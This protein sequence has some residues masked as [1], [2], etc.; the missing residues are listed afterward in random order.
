[1]PL[2]VVVLPPA[3]EP[4]ASAEKSAP[5]YRDED[6]HE[7]IPMGDRHSYPFDF[8]VQKRPEK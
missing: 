2:K 4:P 5:P 7:V 1:M 3:T 6:D 8:R